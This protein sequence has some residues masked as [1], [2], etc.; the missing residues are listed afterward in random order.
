MLFGLLY[1]GPTVA[2]NA[3]C[4]S[5]TIFLN[6]SYAVPVAF[7]L[8]RGRQVVRIS[9]PVFY[10]GHMTGYIMNWISVLFVF[11]TSIFFCFPGFL[12]V[13]ASNMNYVLAVLGIF[14]LFCSALWAAK[15][16]QY[17]GPQFEI[18]LGENPTGEEVLARPEK[19][20]EMQQKELV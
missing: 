14:I 15:R 5:C 6:L 2:F 9:R 11:A 4:A 12:P 3:Y 16:D 18:I 20:L 13:T 1:L 17:N 7:L 10:L 8:I 19:G